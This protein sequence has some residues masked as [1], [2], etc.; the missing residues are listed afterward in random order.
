[1]FSATV[2]HGQPAGAGVAGTAA[3]AA[4]SAAVTLNAAALRAG[5]QAWDALQA[6]SRTANRAPVARLKGIVASSRAEAT[7]LK[8]ERETRAQKFRATARAAKEF[9]TQH[10]AH[11]QAAEARRLE[12]LAGIEGITP[13]DKPYERAALATAAAFRVNPAHPVADRIQVAHAMESVTL[14]RKTLGRPWFANP[15]LAETMLDRLHAEFGE[16]PAIWGHYLALAENTYCDAGNDVAHRIVQSPYA[17][18]PTKAAARRILER[19]ALVR[20]PLDFPL[21]PAQGR[22]TTLGHLAGKTT[23]VCVWDG[24]GHPEGP[25]GLSEF[26]KNPRPNTTWIYVS[27][28]QPGALPK[29]RKATAA[30]PGTTCVEPLGWRSSVAAKL[31]VAQ[32]PYAY[33]LDDRQRLSGYGRIDEIPALLAGIG[34]PALP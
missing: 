19:H 2:L 31:K 3:T 14:A 15:V 18:E 20:R 8:Q 17:P 11:P 16:Q 33:V 7:R 21:T 6:Q 29:G 13:Q 24:A 28:G 34:R 1:M 10:A 22:G 9:H 32:L 23:V 25:P 27:L 5:D 26:K 12:A 4:P 30:P